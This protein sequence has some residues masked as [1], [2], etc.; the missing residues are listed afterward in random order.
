MHRFTRKSWLIYRAWEQS[1]GCGLEQTSK[2]TVSP[3]VRQTTPIHSLVMAGIAHT[4]LTGA[5]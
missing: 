2:Q 5:L 1:G 3:S 4:L